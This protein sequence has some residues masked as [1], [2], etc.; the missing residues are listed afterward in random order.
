MDE[1]C[2]FYAEAI[3]HGYEGL[4]AKHPYSI[5]VPG[6]RTRYWAKIRESP[7]NLDL[8]IMFV[9]SSSSDESKR[10]AYLLGSNDL[11]TRQL[12]PVA[13]CSQGLSEDEKRWLSVRLE[14]VTLEKTNEGS[15][16]LPRIVLEVS[17]RGIRRDPS[18]PGGYW[19]DSPTA[20][21]VRVDK[22]PKEIDSLQWVEKLAGEA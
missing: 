12:V 21:R 17:F 15:T 19:I 5:Y 9:Y 6:V 4:V 2:S 3:N 16:V 22:S 11:R 1:A 7:N 10:E 8:V 18:T 13:K 20:T 14:D